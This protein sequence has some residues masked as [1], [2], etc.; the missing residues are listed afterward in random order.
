[1]NI[2]HVPN[3]VW[4]KMLRFIGIALDPIGAYAADHAKDEANKHHLYK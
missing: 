4:N 1:M 3:F 2:A